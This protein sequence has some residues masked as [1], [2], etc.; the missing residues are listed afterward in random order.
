LARYLLDSSWFVL[1][2]MFI[3]LVLQK[4]RYFSWIIRKR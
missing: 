4:G 3:C 1:L 2:H